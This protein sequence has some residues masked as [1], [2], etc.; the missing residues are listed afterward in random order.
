MATLL[1]CPGLLAMLTFFHPRRRASQ[2]YFLL[3]GNRCGKAEI[4]SCPQEIPPESSCQY[5]LPM[6]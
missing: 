2:P 5:F 6:C 1:L 3:A 4:S